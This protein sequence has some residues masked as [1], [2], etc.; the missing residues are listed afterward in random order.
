MA[1]EFL[2]QDLYKESPM[3]DIELGVLFNLKKKKQKRALRKF[4]KL[5]GISEHI[6]IIDSQT[7]K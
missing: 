7:F 2:N 5:Y 1:S 3:D 6:E 4:K